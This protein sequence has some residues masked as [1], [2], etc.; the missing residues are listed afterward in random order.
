MFL[1][2]LSVNIRPNR[3]LQAKLH[4][5]DVKNICLNTLPAVVSACSKPLYTSYSTS[6]FKEETKKKGKAK[7]HGN[8][9][10]RSLLLQKNDPDVFGDISITKATVD[11]SVG[12]D[13]GDIA[14]EEF[15]TNLPLN[16][17]QL[18]MKQYANIIKEHFKYKRIKEAIDVLEVKMIQVDRV[19]PEQYIY[20]LLIGELGRLGYSKKA[21]RLYNKM[22]QRGLTT[23]AR[24]YTGLFN[25]LANSPFT[26]DSLEQANKLRRIMIE[27]GYEPN[28]KNYNAMIKTYGR[29]ND[30]K[31]AF[32]LVDEMK[33][34]KLQMKL[35]TYNFLLQACNSDKEYGF[36]HALI[37][38]HKIYQRNLK[39]DIYSFNLILRCVRDCSIGDFETMQQVIATILL[40]S[41]ENLARKA[42][43]RA[44]KKKVQLSDGMNANEK[45]I[46]K[47]NNQI[48]ISENKEDLQDI[49]PNLL[50]DTPH[51]GNL[52]E[53]KHIRDSGDRL[54]LLG[55]ISGFISE[56][57]KAE[58][59]PDIKT[60]TQ[61]MDVIPSTEAAEHKLITQLRKA[62]VTADVDFFNMLMK[63]RSMRK[64]YIGAKVC[65]LE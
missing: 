6:N 41:K 34:K 18:T 52:I 48:E 40:Q 62:K 65:S 45:D 37:V 16:S 4:Q 63:K 57:E 61:L 26:T 5:Y 20:N 22:K 11:E 1:R 53:L 30:L 43:K 14:E 13:E 50:S 24:T 29:C 12:D 17:Q 54:L 51:L 10:E 3:I 19:K 56:M 33:E 39:P 9:E 47:N 28:E 35:D 15:T 31:N 55:G 27:K 38:W 21:F 44:S 25:S 2:I 49:T 32:E 64:D 46:A 42:E 58:V 7:N 23:G 8:A 36:R 60:F 59:V